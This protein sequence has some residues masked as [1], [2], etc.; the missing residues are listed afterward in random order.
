MDGSLIYNERQ[1]QIVFFF[2]RAGLLIDAIE[3]VGTFT[4]SVYYY[5]CRC[6]IIISSKRYVKG[7]I[8]SRVQESTLGNVAMKAQW[9]KGKKEASGPY[10]YIYRYINNAYLGNE[11]SGT[12][13]CLNPIGCHESS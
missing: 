11:N 1:N 8:G 10:T 13:T 9:R 5:G 7:A 4:P 2:L 12:L 3:Y 6:I